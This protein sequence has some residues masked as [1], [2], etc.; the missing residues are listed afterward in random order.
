LGG[1]CALDLSEVPGRAA[2]CQEFNFDMDELQPFL[3]P[4]DAAACTSNPAP[5]DGAD[6]NPDQQADDSHQLGISDDDCGDE[7]GD[8]EAMLAAGRLVQLTGRAV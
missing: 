2:L 8:D 5:M 1:Y 7:E 4:S 3:P 6:T